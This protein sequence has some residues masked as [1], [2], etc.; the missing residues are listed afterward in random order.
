MGLPEKRVS[1]TVRVQTTGNKVNDAI[2]LIMGVVQRRIDN[3]QVSGSSWTF[4]SFVSITMRASTNVAM[5][6]GLVNNKI[7]GNGHGESSLILSQAE[8][9]GATADDEEEQE[10][11]QDSEMADFIDDRE[12]EEGDN[13]TIYREIDEEE[14]RDRRDVIATPTATT[15][16]N[17]PLSDYL[18][19]E[20][21][22]VDLLSGEDSDHG[23]RE[24]R[25]KT[26]EEACDILGVTLSP[27][28]AFRM[29]AAID[30]V[31]VTTNVEDGSCTYRAIL[32]GLFAK[33]F[34]TKEVVTEERFAHQLPAL[35]RA[36]SVY[37][38]ALRYVTVGKVGDII[39]TL[40]EELVKMGYVVNI[41]E[42]KPKTF[43][44]D[45]MTTQKKNISY[46]LSVV[47]ALYLYDDLEDLCPAQVHLMFKQVEGTRIL[48]M[49]LCTD[50]SVIIKSVV[51]DMSKK[52]I[53]T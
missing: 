8:D 45:I 5:N 51:K 6:S 7:G 39:Q 49:G 41:Y 37:K 17:Y 29:N 18:I 36:V 21:L 32:N 44:I 9:D 26:L 27:D 19:P 23:D 33:K 38:D 3:V 13:R 24:P 43:L 47:R 2:D 42:R 25:E 12:V 53:I 48:D 4:H 16:L 34:G 11:E 20:D 15:I 10:E 52:T 28:T 30:K 35:Y 22:T 14:A 46:L 1:D 40:N 31:I 50:M